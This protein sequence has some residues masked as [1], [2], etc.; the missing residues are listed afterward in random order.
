MGEKRMVQ[1]ESRARTPMQPASFST[2]LWHSFRQSILK[3]FSSSPPGILTTLPCLPLSP[4]ST[5]YVNCCTRDNKTL[6]LL[7]ANTA[8][9]LQL[10][11]TTWSE[12]ARDALRDCFDTTDWEVLCGPHEQDIDSLTDCITDYI[13]FCVETTVPTKRSTVFLKQQ[14]LGDS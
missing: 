5:R 13:N 2:V 10:I 8:G 3:P 14:A 1:E 6:D 12:E 7:S 9:A 11:T 4:T